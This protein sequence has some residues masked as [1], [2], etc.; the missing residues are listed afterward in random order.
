MYNSSQLISLIYYASLCINLL[1]ALNNESPAS[2]DG[3]HPTEWM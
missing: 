2:S 1:Q 3:T